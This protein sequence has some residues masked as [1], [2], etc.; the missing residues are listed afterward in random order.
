MTASLVPAADNIRP[1]AGI[2]QESDSAVRKDAT[3]NGPRDS[4]GMLRRSVSTIF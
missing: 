4:G 2:R 1:E 3:V